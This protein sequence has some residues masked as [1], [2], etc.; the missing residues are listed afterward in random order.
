M[1]IAEEYNM[2]PGSVPVAKLVAAL[3]KVG[4][5][6]IFDTN[7]SADLT[8]MEEGSELLERVRNGGPFPMFTSCCPGWVN[9][10]EKKRPE[11]IS[12]LSS[13]RSPQGMLGSVAKTYFAEKLGKN[14]DEIV[15]VSLMPCTA[16]KDEAKRPQL[17]VDGNPDVDFALTTRELGK[18]LKMKHISLPTMPD[19]EFDKPLGLSTGA[20]VI[21]GVTGG[22]MEAALRTA[23][24][25]GT[26]KHL[27]KLNFEDVRGLEGIKT[28][29]IDFAGLPL[30]VAVAHGMG[31]VTKLLSKIDKKE[32]EPFHFVEMM[33]CP[34]GCIGGGGETK[35]MEK[36]ILKKRQAAIYS[37]DERSIIRKSHENPGIKELYEKF[38]EKPLS[39]KAHHLLHT[40]YNDRSKGISTSKFVMSEEDQHVDLEN[41][42]KEHFTYI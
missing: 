10:V 37:L 33:A 42:I 12:S 20:A 32:V 7:F 8:I 4:F 21:F 38:L 27:E 34:G 23:Y 26:G 16:K 18:L 36:D 24:E 1:A 15:V 30:R 35:S 41:Q 40:H 14:R 13:S 5:D 25:L 6:Y 11:L 28:A 9:F 29:T 22:V 19:E 31:Q 17:A 3:R 2:A 39:P